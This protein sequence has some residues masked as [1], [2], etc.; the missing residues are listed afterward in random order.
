MRFAYVFLMLSSNL[1]V[2]LTVDH[3]L[4]AEEERER[5]RSMGVEVGEF[6]TRIAGGLSVSRSFGDFECKVGHVTGLSGEP[7][8]YEPVLLDHTVKKMIVASDGVG[9]FNLCE[10]NHISC[11]TSFLVRKLLR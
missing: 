9:L 4:A 8:I 3:K 11:G 5:V 6:Q 2:P 7:Q 1:Q 10:D